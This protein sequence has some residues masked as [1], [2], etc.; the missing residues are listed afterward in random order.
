MDNFKKKNY[1]RFLIFL[2][3]LN[4]LNVLKFIKDVKFLNFFFDSFSFCFLKVIIGK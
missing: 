1:L 3:K 4:G 2:M